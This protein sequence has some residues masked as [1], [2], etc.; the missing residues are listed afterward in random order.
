MIDSSPIQPVYN[1][2]IEFNRLYN[3]IEKLPCERHSVDIGVTMNEVKNI[4]SDLINI[5]K[6]LDS[7]EKKLTNG[8]SAKVEKH[9]KWIEKKDSDKTF[10]DRSWIR[11]IFNGLTSVITTILTLYLSGIIKF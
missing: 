6:K 5:D 2:D 8:L 1:F 7:I 3:L 4:S 9:E 10:L 11:L